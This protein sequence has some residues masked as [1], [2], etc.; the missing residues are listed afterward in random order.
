MLFIGGFMSLN[1]SSARLFASVIVAALVF[2]APG[3]EL[4]HSNRDFVVS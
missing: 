1:A 2:A 4:R 3:Q